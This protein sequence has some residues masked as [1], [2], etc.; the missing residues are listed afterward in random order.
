MNRETI[1]KIMVYAGNTESGDTQGA[2]R[3]PMSIRYVTD[4]RYLDNIPEVQ[5]VVQW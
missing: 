1:E 4:T 5:V 2:F 3:K